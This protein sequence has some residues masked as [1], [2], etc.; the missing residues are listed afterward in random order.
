MIAFPER[1]NGIS[2]FK[3]LVNTK[4]ELEQNWEVPLEKSWQY[5]KTK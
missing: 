5:K 3:N 2:V 1:Q 4:E